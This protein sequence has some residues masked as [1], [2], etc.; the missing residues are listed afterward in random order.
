MAGTRERKASILRHAAAVSEVSP[1]GYLEAM[2]RKLDDAVVVITGA[3][4]GIGRAS[5]RSM[6]HRGASLVLAARGEAALADTVR[7]CEQ[8][9]ARAIGVP[10][11]VTDE[12]A[13]DR[14]ARRAADE[15]GQIDVWVNNAGVILYGR[16]EETE[17]AHFRRVIETNLFGQVHGA[18]AA[19]PYFRRQGSGVLIN[20]ASVWGRVTAPYVSAY[21]TS[22]FALRAFSECLRE[23]LDGDEDI[24]VVTILPQAVDTPIFQHAAN[25][26]GREVRPLP[27][28]CS[29]E[30]IAKRIAW[31]A[32]DPR[33]EVTERRLGRA[34]EAAHTVSPKLYGRIAAKAFKWVA[35]RKAASP[36]TEGN[37][38]APMEALNR[39]EGGHRRRRLAGVVGRR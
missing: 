6:A 30:A 13:V 38:F 2:P 1:S 18:R 11:D 8:I 10:T 5:A 36:P 26:S 20:M 12:E 25:F 27:F 19:L 28:M 21:V 4:S 16:F 35:L 37:L 39:A 17:A 3:S 14:L 23:E 24:N 22:K 7:E 9:G 34:L 15:Y 33:R 29:P 31:C 32:E